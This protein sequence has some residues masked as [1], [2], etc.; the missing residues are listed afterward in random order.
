MRRGRVWATLAWCL[1]AC[2]TSAASAQTPPDSSATPADAPRTTDPAEA[3][4][5]SGVEAFDA[6]DYEA[7]L[8]RFRASYRLRAAPAVLYNIAVAE[9]M[10]GRAA[11]ACR[12]LRRYLRDVE[13]LPSER[14]TAVERERS[15]IC[16]EV[17]ELSLR[18]APGG[19]SVVVDGRPI[20]SSPM[21]EP[22]VLEPGEHDVVVSREG[23]AV[24]RREL[25]LARGSRETLTVRLRRAPDSSRISVSGTS[26]RPDTP[27]GGSSVLESP[28]LWTALGVV[29]VG[30]AAGIVLVAHESDDAPS[31]AHVTFASPFA[32]SSSMGSER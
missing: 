2:A 7:A 29:V 21:T 30:A 20:G 5:R 3:A 25:R 16:R 18:I 14:R 23:Y 11:L 26:S 8:A 9:R 15:Q 32:L 28:W 19:A 12:D 1:S 6:G 24:E 31:A 22:M 17:A 4:F 27:A 10:I 13:G